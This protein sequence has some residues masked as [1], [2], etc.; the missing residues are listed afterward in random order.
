MLL[1]RKRSK[2]PSAAL[3]AGGFFYVRMK[4]LLARS[5]G[6][7]YTD[8]KTLRL[9]AVFTPA[10]PFSLKDRC[11]KVLVFI[12]L[13]GVCAVQIVVLTI[14]PALLIIAAINDLM[15]FRI[16]NWVSLAL[17]GLFLAAAPFAGMSWMIIG[18]HLA[19]GAALLLVGMAMFALNLL[20]GGDA[21]LLA[22]VGIWMGWA[23]MPIYLVWAA[24]AGGL[25]ALTILMFRRAPLVAAAAETPWIARLHDKQAGIPYG[26]ALA[27]GALIALPHTVWFALLV[28]PA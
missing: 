4:R 5:K 7:A 25:L 17:L 12:Q 2:E 9:Y 14:L 28:T 23:A 26:I 22:A 13:L 3:R 8:I 15:T 19:L 21:K 11:I 20:G 6:P 27:A 10:A 1:E 24:I 18:S 16:P